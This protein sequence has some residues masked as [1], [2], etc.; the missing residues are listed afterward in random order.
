MTK[1]TDKLKKLEIP[2]DKIPNGT[3]SPIIKKQKK[4]VVKQLFSNIPKIYYKSEIYENWKFS[5]DIIYTILYHP[6]HYI[7]MMIKLQHD[8]Y[9]P[10]PQLSVKRNKIEKTIIESVFPII[11]T[12]MGYKYIDPRDNISKINIGALLQRFENILQTG[13]CQEF[14]FF[15]IFAIYWEKTLHK[16]ISEISEKSDFDYFLTMITNIIGDKTSEIFL[17][18]C[19]V[20]TK[21]QEIIKFNTY[22]CCS[23]IT[24]II[25]CGTD[26][27][28]EDNE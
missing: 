21:D 5:D 2:K 13:N 14:R 24:R 16:I 23:Y 25:E 18:N 9:I 6:R 26:Y 22:I 8:Q 10:H 12:S 1:K 4:T 7:D 3:S 27:Y 15:M 28:N 19:T 11:A 20:E 17:S